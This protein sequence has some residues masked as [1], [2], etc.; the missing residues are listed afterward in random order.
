MAD[1]LGTLGDDV[2]DQARLGLADWSGTIKGL[3]GND[4]LSGGAIH[5]QGGAG[6]DVLTGLSGSTTV[7]YYD[8]PRGV[9][10]NLLEGSAL[11][12][13]G[14]VDTLVNIHI[15]HGSGFS[16][17][18][19]GSQSADNFWVGA[20]D[21]VYANSGVDTVTVWEQSVDWEL[22]NVNAKQAQLVHKST[23]KT[24]D[25]IDAEFVQFQDK[26]LSLLYVEK[27]VYQDTNPS[28]QPD[29]FMF[30]ASKDI[31]RDGLWDVIIGAGVAP[32][33]PPI[34]TPTQVLIQQQN[35][36]FVKATIA[37]SVEGFIHPREI[38]TGDFN[39]D[40][41][42][43]VVV[44]G[45]GY[46]TSP[47]PGETPTIY[48]GQAGG[49][50]IDGSEALPQTPAFTHSVAV[51]DVN[52]DKIDDLFL[53]NIY[54]REEFTPR[55]LLGQTNSRFIEV[56]LPSSIGAGA[57][58]IN[59]NRPVASLL[60]DV[61][62]DGFIDLIA[63]GDLA[64]Y[65]YPGLT[66]AHSL[67]GPFF[68][69]K[70]NLPIGFFGS[71]NS[72]TVDIQTLDLNRDGRQDL[73]L[74]QT[75]IGYQGGRAI[76]VLVQNATGQWVD[77]TTTRMHGW[78]ASGDW[79]AFVNL[80]DLNQDGH[81]DLLATSTTKYFDCAFINNGK[82][83]F[84]PAGSDN[85]VPSIKGSS[86]L[87]AQPGKVLSV[88]N[89]NTGLVSVQAIDIPTGHTG[90]QS[91]LP[92]LA[93]APGFNE[94]YY[95]HMHPEIKA[96]V[97]AGQ[98]DSGL[99]AYLTLGVAAGHRGY[100]P[101][102]IVW[103]HD[104]IDLVPYNG[105]HTAYSVM[106]GSADV[107]HLT[108]GS[109]G[110]TPDVLRGVERVRFSDSS[111]ALDLSDNAGQVAKTL[112]AVF[113]KDAVHNKSFVGIGLHFVDELNYSYP[114]LMQLAINARLGANATNAQVVDLLYTNV[115]G[116]APDAATRKTFTDLLDNG[117]F[118]VG[119][120]GVLAADTELNKTNIN[121]TG[122]AQTGLEYLPFGG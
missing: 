20:G 115:V 71:N 41:F 106:R 39:G 122:L 9:S 59:G 46:D 95:L 22:R 117:T 17:T 105:L 5:L 113:G 112:G 16:D 90:P 44:V 74:S 93:G 78:D 61:T 14:G 69:E 107:W 38:G 32:P 29:S 109:T 21:I 52:G 77:E 10:V 18:F 60:A 28:I 85:G 98:W 81:T 48:W 15:V 11:D 54:G 40:G 64:V 94:Q 4:K 70:T 79:I 31:N 58:Q 82:G 12:G 96:A 30:A 116:Q 119:G 108:G 89:T 97:A 111:L 66:T 120:L 26:T 87:P 100:A 121:L 114:D 37:G 63:G 23:G 7:N 75:T 102:T 62:G 56:N 84:Y 118:T 104:G 42:T 50:F 36:T 76:Q 88:V 8:A 110:Q 34:E 33:S 2:L 83:H 101:G 103:G 92:A 19:I 51:A 24:I 45:H 47:F 99:S 49:G 35:G 65:V 68:A 86:L 72:H 57:L 55:L 3:S 53:G 13:W 73:L 6:N 25:L 43:D 67:T 91:T 27:T 80:V 1:F